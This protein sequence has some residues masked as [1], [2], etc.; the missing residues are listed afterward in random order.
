MDSL[1]Q[2]PIP[3]D[4]GMGGLLAALGGGGAGDGGPDLGG[5]PPDDGGSPIDGMDSVDLIKEAIKLLIMA[6]AKEDDDERGTGITK[7]M[8]ALQGILGGEQKKN[9]QLSALGG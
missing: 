2:G 3:S 9:A 8:G 1:N 5:G 7:G 6:F 4:Q